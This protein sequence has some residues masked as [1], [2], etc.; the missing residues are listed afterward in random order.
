MKRHKHIFCTG[1]RNHLPLDADGSPAWTLFTF[2]QSGLRDPA[3]V[4]YHQE[5]LT[6]CHVGQFREPTVVQFKNSDDSR[7]PEASGRQIHQTASARRQPFRG[8]HFH[9]SDAITQEGVCR[10]AIGEA[11][12][13]E[14]PFT[15]GTP[16][17]TADSR[18]EWVTWQ[19]CALAVALSPVDSV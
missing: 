12:R 13:K 1:P 17:Y 11:L 10:R 5:R 4:K 7:R 15:L 14:E 9:T 19:P 8:L 2:A 3:V 16:R 6:E 18:P